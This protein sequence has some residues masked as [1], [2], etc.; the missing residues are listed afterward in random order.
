MKE[1]KAYR[2]L[3]SFFGHNLCYFYYSSTRKFGFFNLF[4]YGIDWTPISEPMLFSQRMGITKYYEFL[5]WRFTFFNVMD[6]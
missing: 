2:L 4:G 3:L 6:I 5:G 1:Y